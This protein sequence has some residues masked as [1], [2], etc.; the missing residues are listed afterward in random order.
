[1]YE[2]YTTRW[3]SNLRD[4]A[5]KF[6]DTTVVTAML[7]RRVTEKSA[8]LF[9]SDGYNCCMNIAQRND[10][11]SLRQ[12]SDTTVVTALVASLCDCKVGK[13]F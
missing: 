4:N 5:S 2:H 3:I 8:K 6:S 1:M 10:L 9:D 13:V 12:C 7:R 11:K